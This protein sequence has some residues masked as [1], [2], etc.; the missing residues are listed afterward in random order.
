M[1][2][3]HLIYVANELTGF[4]MMRTIGRQ[5]FK[6]FG[7]TFLRKH[8]SESVSFTA[9]TIMSILLSRAPVLLARLVLY[10][11]FK[12]RSTTFVLK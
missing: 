9:K 6:V 7:Y 1:E 8:V 2:T 3:S 10:N 11:L 5:R 12:E 4:Y